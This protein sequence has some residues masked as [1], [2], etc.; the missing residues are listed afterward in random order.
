MSALLSGFNVL[1]GLKCVF[2]MA[3][4]TVIYSTPGWFNKHC[5]TKEWNLHSSIRWHIWYIGTHIRDLRDNYR[6]VSNIRRTL[7]GNNIFD[8]APTTS[9]FST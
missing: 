3:V 1:M 2:I 7:A 8:A 5:D 4:V 6:Q 9:S